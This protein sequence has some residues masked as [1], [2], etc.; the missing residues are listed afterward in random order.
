MFL[1]V[2]PSRSRTSRTG[3]AHMRHSSRVY[4]LPL[5]CAWC[6][7]TSACR[8]T[9]ASAG[10]AIEFSAIPV[11]SEGGPDK[12]APIAG[13]VSGARDGQRIVLYARSNVWWVQPFTNKALTT[14]QPDST[15]KSETHLGTEYAALLVEAD[16]HPPA[17]TL[18]LPQPGGG[19]IVVAVVKGTPGGPHPGPTTLR[20]SGYEWQTRQRSGN[21]GGVPNTYEAANAWTDASGFLHLRIG[22]RADQWTAAEVTLKRSLG[23]GT[24]HFVVRDTSHLEPAAV[25]TLYT[26]D[27]SEADPNHREVSIELS[28]WGDP[29][30]KNAQ[31]VIQPYYVPANVA[32]FAA[33]AGVLTH[34]FQWQPGRVSLST[35]RGADSGTRSRPLAEHVFTSGVPVPGGETVH[36]CVYP[37]HQGGTPLRNGAEV[38]IEK[39]EY[40][41]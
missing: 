2:L 34:S 24:Y 23:Y 35:V 37:F 29:A 18:E 31:Y 41:P 20:F 28:R 10:P 33:P 12:L 30:N 16:Y 22:G 39:F 5:L 40:L 27:E 38:V 11:A 25:L 17:K 1:L 9:R 7:L 4:L 36:I 13:R 19:V 26:F 8:S 14:I 32:R 15:W 21:R 6:L 3:L